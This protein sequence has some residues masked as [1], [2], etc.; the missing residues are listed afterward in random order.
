MMDEMIDKTDF[1]N[2]QCLK[3]FK[4]AKINRKLFYEE[5][6]TSKG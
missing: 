6:Q 5:I 4:D 3:R 1:E 2:N